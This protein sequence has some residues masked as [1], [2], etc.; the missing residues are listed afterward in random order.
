MPIVEQKKSYRYI[1]ILAFIL[2]LFVVLRLPFINKE[3]APEETLWVRGGT[4]VVAT[5]FPWIYWGEQTSSR[6]F[7]TGKGPMIDWLL[8]VPYK[9]FGPSEAAS[10][11]I[12]FIFA[13][14]QI[15]LLYFLGRQIFG[16]GQGEKIGLLAAFLVTI[17]PFAVQN[18]IQLDL[19]GGIVG[20]FILLA[21]F[22]AWPLATKDERPGT[23]SVAALSLTSAAVFL[24]RFDTPLM[25][26]FSIC[27]YALIFGNWK[28]ALRFVKLFFFSFIGAVGFL[29]T[30]DGAF[31]ELKSSIAPYI[32]PLSAL[33]GV[34][35]QNTSISRIADAIPNIHSGVLTPLINFIFPRAA[36]AV[37]SFLWITAPLFVLVIFVAGMI[38]WDKKFKDARLAYFLLPA[39]IIFLAFTAVAPAFNYP[40]YIQS[41]LLLGTLAVSAYV[42]GKL[43]NLD[44]RN[45]KKL[46]F[47][48]AA[49]LVA[50]SVLFA[51]NPF[52]KMLFDDRIRTNPT[53]AGV[54]FLACLAAAIAL[55]FLARKEKYITAALLLLLAIYVGFSALIVS[56]DFQKPYSLSAYYGNYGF[57]AAGEFVKNIAGPNDV[58]AAVDPVGYYYGGKYYDAT[59]YLGGGIPGVKPTI[60]AVYDVPAHRFDELTAGKK[61]I[62]TFGT[63]EV[64][65]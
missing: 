58:I 52:S 59:A 42:V 36:F 6:F 5:G 21:V 19:D 44:I 34:G 60:V 29:A 57:K 40:R 65:R 37:S 54:G 35:R 45:V 16:R 17:N 62:A 51:R 31:G 26:F 55:F 56:R 9:I 32:A 49:A 22:F 11:S 63:V 46:C 7:I 23:W 25:V 53:I 47:V 12:P 50:T 33:L 38:V 43:D 20:F 14:G 30:Y 24:V 15:I 10:R 3:Y 8:F 64:Y 27:L 61:L 1:L 39:V 18:A 48:F 13:F 41:A 2:V 28:R 4:S